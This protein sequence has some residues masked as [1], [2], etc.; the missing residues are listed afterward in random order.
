MV[1][2]IAD[3]V[4]LTQPKLNYA[5]SGS[6]SATHLS[7]RALEWEPQGT[8]GPFPPADALWNPLSAGR[9]GFFIPGT[10]TFAVIGHTAALQSGIGYKAVQS[11]GYTCPGPCPYDPADYTNYY[12]FYNVDDILSASELYEP[13]PYA[14]GSFDVPFDGDGTRPII[15]ATFDPTNNTLYLAVKD[16]AQLGTYDRPPLI[17]TY[18]LQ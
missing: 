6:D 5:Y 16:A 9:Y 8:P 2:R 18:K 13:R 1:K 7:K 15:G 4:V 10:K 14:Y 17:V 12:W 11:D 3:P